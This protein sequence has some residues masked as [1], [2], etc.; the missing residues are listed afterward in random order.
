MVHVRGL[1]RGEVDL[2]LPVEGGLLV[3]GYQLVL[4]FSRL[5]IL[6]DRS[7]MV[8]VRSRRK[9]VIH[10]VTQVVFIAFR[11]IICGLWYN[12]TFRKGMLY[13]YNMGET[14]VLT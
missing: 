12:R 3:D 4:L 8:K 2:V 13:I 10:L 5:V 6:S 9:G 14:E 1:G 7:L 11:N